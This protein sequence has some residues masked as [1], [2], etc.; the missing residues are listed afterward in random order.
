MKSVGEVM[1]IG[2]TFAES[3]QKALR[4]L[5]TGLSGLDEIEIPD[6]DDPEGGHAAIVRALG[7][8]TP[9]R[10]RVIAQAFRHGLTVDEVNRACSY[11]A[12]VPAP[13]RRHCPTEKAI[14][15]MAFRTTPSACAIS[16]PW[17]FPTS[18]WPS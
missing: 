1:A 16:R 2:R 10:L 13:T 9:D 14:R 12:V 18:V 8:P 7:Q 6:A 15:G 4:G 3:L 5:E 11:R 17:V